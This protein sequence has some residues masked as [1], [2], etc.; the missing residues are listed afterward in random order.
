MQMTSAG[1]GG[2]RGLFWRPGF[3]GIPASTWKIGMFLSSQLGPTPL[4][5]AEAEHCSLRV[6]PTSPFSSKSVSV[7][8]NGLEPHLF[9]DFFFFLK[10]LEMFVIFNTA[11]CDSPHLREDASPIQ[12]A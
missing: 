9:A 6:E 2:Q 8:K 7:S 5:L 11:P 12:V 10:T 1:A 4:S 3:P